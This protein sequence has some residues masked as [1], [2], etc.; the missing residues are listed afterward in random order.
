MAALVPQHIMQDKWMN[1]NHEGDELKP[2]VEP[3]PDLHDPGRI[4][5]MLEMGFS[6]REIEDSLT[7]N[8]YDEVCATYYL[9]D[10]C[11]SRSREVGLYVTY[12]LR[13]RATVDPIYQSVC[14]SVRMT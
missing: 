10:R 2:Y 13:F 11:H 5:R 7:D 8:K 6:Q 9:L 1:L 12:V 4:S 14:D 3:S